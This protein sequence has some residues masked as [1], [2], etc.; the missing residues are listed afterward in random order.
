MSDDVLLRRYTHADN[1]AA[2]LHTQAFREEAVR[3][4]SSARRQAVFVAVFLVVVV[5]FVNTFRLAVVSGDSMESTYVSGQV[6]LVRRRNWL[7]QSLHDNDVVLVRRERDVIIKRI[8]RMPGEEVPDGEDVV[9]NVLEPSRLNGLLDYYEQQKTNAPDGPRTRYSVPDGYIVVLGD[10]LRV[11]EDSRAFGPVPI[12]DVLG[13]VVGAPG[14]PYSAGR[15]P[16][17]F[18]PRPRLHPL[19]ARDRR[20]IVARGSGHF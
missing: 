11:S 13:V 12:R 2:G 6:V 7:N 17:G 15:L 3:A 16:G 14:P 20:F 1:E 8:Y 9:P 18:S 5:L 4:S 10:N 19:T